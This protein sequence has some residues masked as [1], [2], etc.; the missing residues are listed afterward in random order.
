MKKNLYFSCFVF[1]L[2]LMSMT[3]EPI[4]RNLDTV[5]VSFSENK[6][7]Y[8]VN[9]TITLNVVGYVDSALYKNMRII[10]MLSVKNAYGEYES[11]DFKDF[12]AS[13]FKE[14][15]SSPEIYLNSYML[16][17][18]REQF[19]FKIQNAGNYRLFVIVIAEGKNFSELREA[20]YEAELYFTVL[21]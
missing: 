5:E 13:A 3:C 2:S 1:L 15:S 4:Y 9:D 8:N 18:V 21:G 7:E 11:A 17:D 6:S 14:N 19:C 10:P 12:Y 16:D 20:T